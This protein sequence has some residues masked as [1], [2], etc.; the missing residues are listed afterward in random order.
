MTETRYRLLHRASSRRRLT[1]TAVL[2]LL[3]VAGCGGG[4]SGPSGT[5]WPAV[6]QIKEQDVT[7]IIIQDI[8]ET[9]DNRFAVGL[10]D[11]QQQPIL[12]ADVSFR[13]YQIDGE[14]SPRVATRASR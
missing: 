5:N 9:G 8:I 2:V 10:L 3:L 7:P 11:K 13:L 1:T 12:H 4:G 6:Q 14:M